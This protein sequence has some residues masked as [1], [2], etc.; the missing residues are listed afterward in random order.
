MQEVLV[1]DNQEEVSVH[2]RT[3]RELR[4]LEVTGEA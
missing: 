4:I 3:P 2:S 1:W